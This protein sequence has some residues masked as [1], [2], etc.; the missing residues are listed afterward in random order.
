MIFAILLLVLVSVN[1]SKAQDPNAEGGHIQPVLYLYTGANRNS[2]RTFYYFT[3]EAGIETQRISFYAG[4]PLYRYANSQSSGA[5]I[6][7]Q[8]MT[9][10]CSMPASLWT[11]LSTKSGR[12]CISMNERRVGYFTTA[13]RSQTGDTP[14]N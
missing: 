5:G 8:P 14:S 2:A 9:I 1:I 6:G 7:W 12:D 11:C 13:M 4:I 10:V 3:P